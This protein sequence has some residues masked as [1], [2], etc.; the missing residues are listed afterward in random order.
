MGEDHTDHTGRRL[1]VRQSGCRDLASDAMWLDRCNMSAMKPQ[2]E[3]AYRHVASAMSE[4]DKARRALSVKEEQFQQKLLLLD[5]ASDAIVACDPDG[6]V[7]FW[8]KG[9][10]RMFGWSRDEAAGC[11][12][13]ALM[14]D[15][16]NLAAENG[17][18]PD[19]AARECQVVDKSGKVRVVEARQ[20][21]MHSADGLPHSHLIAFT[22]ITLRRQAEAEIRQL[23]IRDP[24]TSLPNRRHLHEKLQQSVEI[25]L[26][27]EIYGA[28]LIVD[29]DNFRSISGNLGQSGADQLLREF[30]ARLQKTLR[31]G[32]CIARVDIDQFAFLGAMMGDTRAEAAAEAALLAQQ[33]LA[34]L[35]HPFDISGIAQSASASIGIT[36]FGGKMASSDAVFAEAAFALQA[37]KGCGPSSVRYFDHGM[38]TGFSRRTELQSDLRYA[39]AQRTLDIH[40]QLQV[41]EDGKPMG[42]EALARWAHPQHGDIPPTEFIPLA[43]DAGLI[44]PLGQLILEKA[45]ETLASWAPTALG[46]LSIAVNVSSLQ[47]RQSDFV[48]SVVDVLCKTGANPHRLK[49]EIT[50]SALVEDVDS[51]IRKMAALKEMGI[52]FSVDDFGTGYSSLAYLKMLPLDQLKIDRAFV[53]D[54]STGAYDAS[55]AS[56]IIL[57]ANTLRL[58]VI[59]EG[60][61]TEEQRARLREIG[62]KAYQ[63]Y[64]FGRPIPLEQLEHHYASTGS[65]LRQE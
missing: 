18:G 22:D 26:R 44:C 65:S 63:G 55:I 9:A 64:L 61:E 52:R 2:R 59:A 54:I 28:L 38:R 16:M 23:A 37:A 14:C 35:R 39:I 13:G 29:L 31:D 20:S 17:S 60:V 47:L 19:T 56:A 7:T 58:N 41:D 24:L 1:R 42:A 57:L 48:Q 33:L 8:N 36:V 32:D 4:R 49:L 43:E 46:H 10:E 62:C 30:P 34:E 15:C 25:H 5:T 6:I 50:E 11:T 51:A 40:Y 45:C 3:A 21:T 53:K 12:L 27:H